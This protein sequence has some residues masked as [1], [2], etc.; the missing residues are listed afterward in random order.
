MTELMR[1]RRALMGMQKSGGRLPAEYQEV[2]YIEGQNMPAIDT[3]ISATIDTIVKFCFK[4]TSDG[5]PLYWDY[6][7][8]FGSMAPK[9]VMSYRVSHI[10][11]YISIGGMADKQPNPKTDLSSG[12]HDIEIS[13]T[14]YKVDGVTTASYSQPTFTPDPNG[15]IYVF[16]RCSASYTLERQCSAQFKSFQI[17]QGGLLVCDLVPCYRKS[18][19][20][21]GMYDLV[22]QAFRTNIGTGSF[23]KGAD[24]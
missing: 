15:T 3:G 23:T 13:S 5:S 16:G 17:Y 19:N 10:D 1:R 24:V 9:Y 20:V 18:D 2:E 12:F 8:V 22:A 6:P 14:E 21:V 7:A 4:R 11:V